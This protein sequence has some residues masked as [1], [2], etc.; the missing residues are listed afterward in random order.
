MDRRPLGQT[1]LAVSRVLLGCGSIGGIGSPAVT[2]GKGLSPEEGLEQIETA[3]AMGINTLDTA[4]SYGGGVS[5][6][7]VGQWIASHPDADVLV[8]S[9]VGNLVRQDQQGID[10]SPAHIVEQVAISLDRLGRIDLYLSHAPD[11]NTP[12]ETTL[13]AFAAVLENG[14]ARAI[15]G[16]HLT[17]NELETALEV[18]ERHGL[19]GYQWV[20]NEYNLLSRD[21]EAEL[22]R[23][24]REHGLGYT[25]FS[26]LAGGVLAG[27]YQRGAAPPL[28]SRMAIIPAYLPH[29]DESL[30]DA[31]EGLS[32]AA[33]RRDVSVPALALAWVLTGP[34]VTAP[35]VAPRRPEQFADVQQALEIELDE[36][37]RAE[38]AA[39]FS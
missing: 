17:A 7:V 34:D 4:N 1:G 28:D 5:E 39:L 8:A 38:L 27:R 23:T 29:I 6:Q 24:V 13:E 22:L 21:D 9:K 35:L 32:A 25:P 19:P 36:D 30:W 12:I 3:V 2:R 26:P 31:L 20:Q 14:Q 16:C 11:P 15:G 10:L 18:A 33:R 37:E